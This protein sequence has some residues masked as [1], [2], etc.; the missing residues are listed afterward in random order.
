MKMITY[1]LFS[2]VLGLDVAQAT[3]QIEEHVAYEGEDWT[4]HIFKQNG[5]WPY[6]PFEDY[7]RANNATFH[8]YIE[9]AYKENEH[10]FTNSLGVVVRPQIGFC[11]ACARGYVAK[12]KIK[13]NQLYLV[14]IG[15]WMRDLKIKHPSQ[16]QNIYPLAVFSSSWKSP[17][18]AYWVTQKVLLAAQEKR[19]GVVLDD[20][21][22]ICFDHY[23]DKSTRSLKQVW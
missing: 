12:W 9:S 7:L 11:T 2:L 23:P 8:S 15:S 21:A 10:L 20:Y 14:E 1:I 19:N 16:I 5:A 18:F 3:N 4:I 22:R 13:D 17:V 6:F